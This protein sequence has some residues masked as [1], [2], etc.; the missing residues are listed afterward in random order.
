MSKV[1]L[2]RQ[3]QRQQ[4][5]IEKYDREIAE[6]GKPQTP[7]PSEPNVETPQEPVG[8]EPPESVQPPAPAPSDD[9]WKQRF[10]TLKGKY[11]AEVPRLHNELK[12]MR[13]QLNELSARSKVET[14]PEP[15]K[16]KAKRITEKDTETFGAD[17]LD[18]M[19]RQAEEIAADAIAEL[20]N[21]VSQLASENEQLKQQV[22]GVSST[23]A[24]TTQAMY[25]AELTKM[26]PDWETINVDNGFLTWLGEVDELSGQPRQAYLDHAYQTLNAQQTAKLFAAYKRTVAPQ[27]SQQP[28]QKQQEV[29]RQ[30]APGK[31]KAPP[32]P[33]PSDASTKI[34][35]TDEIEG[36]YR[37]LRSGHYRTSPQEAARIEAEIDAAVASGRVRG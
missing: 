8:Q 17:L 30:V 14:P 32:G 36:F 24:Q 9:Q 22:T 6:A 23:Q 1:D 28:S 20:Q 7:A 25:L 13:T 15:A 34:W 27:Q 10:L 18:V 2:P 31:T 37:D 12:E 29:Q 11:D 35:S 19:K 3:L 5:D 21:K 4:E 33:T 16:P 26:V